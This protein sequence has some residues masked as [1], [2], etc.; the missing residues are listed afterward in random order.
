MTIA[1]LPVT[2]V[3]GQHLV[4]L[5]YA[6][7]ECG[8]GR[9]QDV[10]EYIRQHGFLALNQEDRIPYPT[11]TEP[12]WMTDIAWAR[13]IGVLFGIVSAEERNAWELNRAGATALDSVFE[14]A[15]NGRL[16]VSE[17]FL[18]STTFRRLFVPSYA[19]SSTELARPPRRR[20]RDSPLYYLSAME[21]LFEQGRGDVVAE[22]LT[23]RLGRPIRMSAVS[24]ALAH[25]EWEDKRS[26]ELLD[27][28]LSL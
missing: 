1:D 3:D 26:Q 13:K 2:T 8:G 14:G 9:R 12:A 10:T 27:L 5:L 24:C 4:C 19:P 11:Q 22:K 28:L 23:E 20:R 16:A 7:R 6:L 21:E 15:K 18:W 17:C 25:K